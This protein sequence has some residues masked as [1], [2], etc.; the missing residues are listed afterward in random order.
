LVLP[1]AHHPTVLKTFSPSF[2][3]IHILLIFVA[4]MITFGLD[5]P[6]N[7]GA[8]EIG[9]FLSLIMFGVV[10]VQG[11]VYFRNS[12]PDRTGLKLLVSARNLK[13]C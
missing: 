5:A 6:E 1:F 11:Y 4:A 7:L 8:M 13:R 3:F 10:A 2:Y 12:R 9:V